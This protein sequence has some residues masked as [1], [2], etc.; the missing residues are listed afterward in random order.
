MRL[1]IMF[2]IDIKHDIYI[3]KSYKERFLQGKSFKVRLNGISDMYYGIN[4]I[5]IR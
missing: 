4:L 1:E 3:E 5:K 2:G